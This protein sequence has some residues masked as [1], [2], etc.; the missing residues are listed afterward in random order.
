MAVDF[1]FSLPLFDSE[2]VHIK[3]HLPRKHSITTGVFKSQHHQ[4]TNQ[5]IVHHYHHYQKPLKKVPNK[6]IVP[7]LENYYLSELDKPKF[8]EETFLVETHS[9]DLKPKHEVISSLGA[10][11]PIRTFAMTESNRNHYDSDYTFQQQKNGGQYQRK[12]HLEEV[13][14][15]ID[16]PKF[17]TSIKSEGHEPQVY[18]DVNEEP[19]M[20]DFLNK[21][22]TNHSYDI[23]YEYVSPEKMQSFYYQEVPIYQDIPLMQY[24]RPVSTVTIKEHIKYEPFEGN[25]DYLQ[26]E[27]ENIKHT[28]AV[29]TGQ[30]QGIFKYLTDYQKYTP[31]SESPPH[32][33]GPHLKHHS[34]ANVEVIRPKDNSHNQANPAATETY[35]G[36]DSYTAAHVQGLGSGGYSNHKTL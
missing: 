2:H 23:Q 6:E 5:K 17:I 36:Y 9:N 32:F 28:S 21:R 4:H 19:Q 18:E 22:P 14:Q 31:S 33:N 16:G 8:L 34:S 10:V 13:I 25:F 3:V 35:T 1:V 7:V 11:Q 26:Q 27:T 15:I 20:D 12:K 24:S 30:E 29:V